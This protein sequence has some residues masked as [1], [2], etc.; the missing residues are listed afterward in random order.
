M[1]TI[2]VTGA[3]G[4]IAS[5]IAAVNQTKFNWIKMTRKD[6]DLSDPDAVERFVRSQDFDL[7]L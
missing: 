7:C 4:Y 2:L 3:N 6:A 5:Y 1:K